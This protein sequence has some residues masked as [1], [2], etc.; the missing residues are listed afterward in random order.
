MSKNI[1]NQ[2]LLLRKRIIELIQSS[3]KP[4]KK[5]QMAKALY[6]RGAQRF[7]FKQ[8]LRELQESGELERGERRR[9]GLPGTN[10][11]AILEDAISEIQAESSTIPKISLQRAAQRGGDRSIRRASEKPLTKGLIAAEVILED[12]DGEFYAQPVNWVPQ[13]GETSPPR[14]H[15]I[16]LKE[17]FRKG[18]SYLTHGSRV[19]VMVTSREGGEW[20]A[21]VIRRILKD[22]TVHLG[23]FQPSGHG[24]S[25][26]GMISSINRRD[27]FP[28]THIRHEDCEGLSAGDIVQYSMEAS[29]HVKILR[30]LGQFDDPHMFSQIAIHNH[31][32]PHVFSDKSIQEA[33]SGKI[34]SLGNRTDF[35][36]LDLVTID[37]EDARDFDDAVWAKADE[38]PRNVGGWR[39]IVA[40][41]DV[42]YYVKM[43][44][45]LDKE[46]KERG[47]SVYFPDR[48]VPMLPE[49]LSNEMC[50]LKPHVERACMAIEMVISSGGKLKS[51]KVKRGLMKSKARLTYNQVQA[52]IDGSPDEM[53][54]PLLENVI[55]P[56]YGVY[57]S[58]LKA[59][60]QR[61]TLDLEVPE[62]QILFDEKGDVRDIVIRQRFDSHKLI[63]ELM[64]AAN[65][66]AAKTLTAKNWPCLF[67]VHDRPESSRV[68]NLHQF[69]KPYKLKFQRNMDPSPAQFNE[70]LHS[71][72]GKPFED[73]VNQL[74]LRSQCQAK[75]SPENLGHFGLSLSH[76][77]HFTSPIRRY[78][79]LVIHRSLIGALGL[80][81]DGYDSKP[82]NLEEIGD[83]ISLRERAAVSAEREVID[84]YAISYVSHH[85]GE[86]FDVVITGLNRFGLFVVMPDSG[87]E[88]FIPKGSLGDG[89]GD[90]FYYD[91]L[92]AHM[93]GRRSGT[94]FKLGDKIR[95]TLME[96]NITTNNL[97][98]RLVPGR[99]GVK[100]G[101][102]VARREMGGEGRFSHGDKP[103]SKGRGKPVS[104]VG[105]KSGAK[106]GEKIGPKTAAKKSASKKKAF[107]AK[108]KK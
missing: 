98:F 82:Q 23:I 62:R 46:A 9:F 87:A 71:V 45:E 104:R 6:I 107:K 79:D 36:D 54:Q 78:A 27:T 94:R 26:A 72:K 38:D 14:I 63:E 4:L 99:G 75:Y 95:A 58:L 39:A 11:D 47:N 24:K 30:T 93:V 18:S 22:K 12:D 89:I 97:I 34:P 7:V 77:A 1:K 84:R 50:S 25:P 69:L 41:A 16:N 13:K 96:A 5:S 83:H 76:Y 102:K 28:G 73:S 2:E 92:N 48:V 67:R 86:D 17:S 68:E 31:N 20:E 91:E 52:A 108:P 55:Q 100:G 35:R 10:P 53:T 103:V 44:S 81:N 74:V 70:L 33:E 60:N 88:G 61:G 64:I 37:G 43:G 57:K 65:V 42:S 49:A 29:G 101:E 66:A 8:I 32:L 51:Y 19:A 21:E 3:D 80:G 56:L 40:I 106:P 85:V 105:V 15:L 90:A 59:R